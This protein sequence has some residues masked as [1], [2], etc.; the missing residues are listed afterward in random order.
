MRPAALL[1][2]LLLTP[3][4]DAWEQK[5]AQAHELE[6]QGDCVLAS[7]R[8]REAMR[9]DPQDKE[10]PLRL[11]RCLLDQGRAREAE[12]L[13]EMIT[14]GWRPPV[15]ALVLLGDIRYDQDRVFDALK[16]WKTAQKQHPDPSVLE[17]IH[18]AE[19]EDEV[20]SDY[21][22]VTTSHFQRGGLP[23]FTESMPPRY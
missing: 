17:K 10:A 3:E 12:D 8:Y 5:F 2:L 4:G 11:A 20:D 22:T 19:R 13:L 16:L 14:A 23:V 9:L 18:K 21:Q 15:E 1:M 6:K 7:E